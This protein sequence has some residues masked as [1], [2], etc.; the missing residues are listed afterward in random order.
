[1]RLPRPSI[2]D[3]IKAEHIRALSESIK[4]LQPRNSPTVRVQETPNGISYHVQTAGGVS[5][6]SVGGLDVKPSGIVTPS[7]VGGVM[8]TINGV[9]LDAETPQK[10]SISPT[11]TVYVVINV[12]GTPNTSTYAGASFVG[13]VLG[14]LVVTIS[15][16]TNEPTDANLTSASGVFKVHLATFVNGQRTAQIGHG[17]ITYL[18]QDLLDGT[19]TGFLNIGWQP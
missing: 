4:R 13:T 11:G 16:S 10:L 1:M 3:P 15:T 7:T 14:S 19:G 12:S 9:R 18:V 5:A 2:G 17:P 6:S 8:P